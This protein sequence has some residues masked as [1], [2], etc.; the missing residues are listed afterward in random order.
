[1][2]KTHRDMT[3]LVLSVLLILGI[4]ALTYLRH[5]QGRGVWAGFPLDGDLLFAGLYI[6]W[7]LVEERMLFG[8]AGYSDFAGTRK[9][10]IP[11]IW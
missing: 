2:A 6:A 4:V 11:A 9:R 3:P 7:I 5:G 8:I 1:M 10:L